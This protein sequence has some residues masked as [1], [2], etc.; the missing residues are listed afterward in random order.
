MEEK[1]TLN[2][3]YMGLI[4]AILAAVC[5]GISFL[6]AFRSQVC[7][8]LQRQGNLIAAAYKQL[9]E[10][11][12]L[13]LF[14]GEGL[15]ITLIDPS[16][17]VLYESDADAS[18]MEN[19]LDR[20]EVQSALADGSGSSRR[21]SDTLG[22][23]D[24]YYAVTLSTGEI[25]RVA[26]SASNIY[27]IYGSA[28]PY[29]VAAICTLMVLAVIFAV[30]LTRRLVEPIKRLPECL[31]DPDLAGDTRRV[32]PELRPFVEEIQQQRMSKETIRQEFTANVSHE[33]KT[34]LTS[35]SGYA[36]MIESGMAKEEDIKRFAGTIHREAGRLLALI[37]DI[38]RL[39]QLDEDKTPAPHT[40][41]ELKS[42]ALE[43]QEILTPSAQKKGII[44]EV[45]GSETVVQ[46]EKNALWELIYN[47]MDNAI[48]YNRINGSVKVTLQDHSI[49]VSDTGIGIA[50]EHQE[51]IFE[52]FYRVDKSHSRATGGTGLGLSI[53]KHVAERHGA[54]IK[55]SSTLGIGTDITILFPDREN[56]R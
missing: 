26:T 9:D 45:T 5:S 8:D 15:R 43:C 12:E 34:P 16:G 33:L 51:R 1:I 42:I 21:T 22:T 3:F 7:E 52:R 40:P 2:L 23:E 56:A 55:L 46:G 28:V 20:P 36:E 37:S 19:H 35:I 4:S 30:L 18:T 13:D 10:P 11:E 49:C 41:V 53:V 14:S 50:P 6:G 17:T 31:D 32:Y 39:S 38:I 47:L 44:I 48:R 29:L 25:L 24:Y 27:Q 54:E